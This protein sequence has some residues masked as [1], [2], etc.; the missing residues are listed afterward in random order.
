MTLTS[1]CG[2]PMLVVFSLFPF[3]FSRLHQVLRPHFEDKRQRV[4]LSG[5][6]SGVCTT[7][8]VLC[9]ERNNALSPDQLSL[10]SKL[11]RASRNGRESGL[12]NNC[13]PCPKRQSNGRLRNDASR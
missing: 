10:C 13:V 8:H 7:T 9:H 12:W 3:V 11:W 6:H 2:T 1:T 4:Q 5:L